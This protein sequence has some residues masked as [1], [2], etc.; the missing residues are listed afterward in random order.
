MTRDPETATLWL[1]RGGEKHRMVSNFIS[2]SSVGVGFTA[3][4][5]G[6]NVDHARA[7]RYLSETGE[8]PKVDHHATQFCSFVRGVEVDDVVLMPDPAMGGVVVGWI[9]G[10]YRYDAGVTAK[11][12]RHRRAVEWIKRIPDSELGERL[13]HLPKTRD[14]L[15]KL[16]DGFARTLVKRATFEDFGEDP[17]DRKGAKVVKV[18]STRTKKPVGPPVAVPSVQKCAGCMMTK[19]SELFVGGSDYCTDCE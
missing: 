13:E 19:R 9:T 2:D 6:T 8:N 4:P 11:E 14:T 15:K 17:T 12:Y 3:I 16:D 1:I 10:P 7:V 18:T 5:D